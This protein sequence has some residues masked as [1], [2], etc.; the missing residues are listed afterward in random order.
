M[1]K[2]DN[3]TIIRRFIEEIENTGDVS[4]IR[5][6]ISEDYVEVYEGN[7][8]LPAS[9]TFL[10]PSRISSFCMNSFQIRPVR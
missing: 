10:S 8:L 3:K 5:E 6:F 1:E 7:Y 9:C 2:W 4:R